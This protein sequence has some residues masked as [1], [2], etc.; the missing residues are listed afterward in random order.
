MSGYGRVLQLVSIAVFVV[1]TAVVMGML[2]Y[3][4]YFDPSEDVYHAP[5]A[6]VP[7]FA[8]A[9]VPVAFGILL[10]VSGLNLARGRFRS[11]G[12]VLVV[13]IGGILC[14]TVLGALF[15]PSTSPRVFVRPGQGTLSGGAII[16]LLGAIFIYDGYRIL[17]GRMS[18]TESPG[19]IFTVP[20]GAL[21]EKRAFRVK[22]GMFVIYPLFLI[23][24]FLFAWWSGRL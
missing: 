23:A 8:L 15:D 2:V 10:L 4:L 5:L 17:S 16:G 6:Y 21:Y 9:L 12:G 19:W 3:L 22:I 11:V 14:A 18:L 1:F 24:V 7:S 13:L 20:K